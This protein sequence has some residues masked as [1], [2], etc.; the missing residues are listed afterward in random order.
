MIGNAVL[1]SYA[2]SIPSDSYGTNVGYAAGTNGGL[3]YLDTYIMAVGA[4]AGAG[5]DN[6]NNTY[7]GAKAG[8]NASS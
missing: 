2:A 1:G 3:E 6:R 8:M 7:L 5:A 4:W